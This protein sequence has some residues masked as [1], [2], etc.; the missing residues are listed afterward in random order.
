MD[1]LEKKLLGR[2]FSDAGS[3]VRGIFPEKE[4]GR[5]GAFRSRDSAPK[6][7]KEFEDLGIKVIEQ[8]TSNYPGC[9]HPMNYT[10]NYFFLREDGTASQVAGYGYLGDSSLRVN[11]FFV[12]DGEVKA[13]I[14][15]TYKGINADPIV[16]LGPVEVPKAYMILNLDENYHKLLKNMESKLEHKD[17][18]IEAYF[19]LAG[20]EIEETEQIRKIGNN[21]KVITDA[22]VLEAC[23]S[24]L[25]KDIVCIDQILNKSLGYSAT[26]AKSAK[27]AEYG[28]FLAHGLSQDGTP[29]DVYIFT[30]NIAD[31]PEKE[32]GV[33]SFDID[34]YISHLKDFIA[35]SL[36]YNRSKMDTAAFPLVKVVNSL[37][38]T[39]FFN[40]HCVAII[41]RHAANKFP[42]TYEGDQCFKLPFYENDSRIG[43]R[44]KE[45]YVEAA[46]KVVDKILE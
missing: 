32:S 22:R 42:S 21:G 36:G 44:F 9:G 10:A 6:V 30:P 17:I 23:P 2:T 34:G 14:A 40:E 4:N 25:E 46:T 20:S 43:D 15:S 18:L 8:Y 11:D 16:T 12:E 31:H 1:N 27:L 13:D 19:S 35:E 37:E 45:R 3:A 5:G 39:D 41:D 7:V 24:L 28:A 33:E 38:E 26:S 29:D